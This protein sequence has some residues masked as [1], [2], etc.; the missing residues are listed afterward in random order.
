[1]LP[2]SSTEDRF[3]W[4]YKNNLWNSN[5]S[6]SGPGSTLKYT[7]NLR[8]ELP[9]LL[10]DYSIKKIFDAPCGDFNWMK[11]LLPNIDVD[12]IGGDIV[13]P[14]IESLNVKYKT[15]NITF[16]HIDLTK[17][18]FPKSDL[19]ICRDCLFHLSFEDTKSVLHN[20]VASGIPYLLTT[21]H[22]INNEFVNRNIPTGDFRVINLFAPP[23]NFPPNP[24]VSIDDSMPDIERQMCLWSREHVSLVLSKLT[25]S[26]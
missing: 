15:H 4:I 23:Y 21:T 14:L 13:L 11:H 10:S 8:K 6:V 7:E 26:N 16:I 9:N 17:D 22:K 2:L 20:F 3:T 1:V 5:E 25:D 24:L 18:P 12:Y 19:M